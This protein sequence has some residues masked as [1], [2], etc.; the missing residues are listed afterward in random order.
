MFAP[1]AVVILLFLLEGVSMLGFEKG[2]AERPPVVTRKL[3]QLANS[4]V[5]PPNASVYLSL[6]DTPNPRM[7]WAAY[8][9][10]QHPLFGTGLVAYS[11]IQNAQDGMNWRITLE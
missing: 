7:Y 11:A 6:T 4:D 10:R 2:L 8:F 5:I 3:I 9:L 1:V